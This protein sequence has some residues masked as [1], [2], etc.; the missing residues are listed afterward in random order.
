MGNIQIEFSAED[1]QEIKRSMDM[2]L[3]FKLGLG[4]GNV[5]AT[6]G[7][8][9]G[10][11]GAIAASFVGQDGAHY[12]PSE[13]GTLWQDTAGTVPATA[14]GDPI[15]RVD[16]I[17]GNNNH[18]LQSSASLRPT[19]R[20]SGDEKW[21][22]FGGTQWLICPAGA[23]GGNVVS[24]TM[25]GALSGTQIGQFPRPIAFGSTD[26]GTAAGSARETFGFAQD[27][28]LRFDGAFAAGATLPTTRHVRRGRRDGTRVYQSVN[29]VQT[30]NSTTAGADDAIDEFV[31]GGG[32]A[33]TLFIGNIHEAI[34]L[35]T[36]IDDTAAAAWDAQLAARHG[37]TL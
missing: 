13:E 36:Y 15:A 14:D 18:A 37:V 6:V 26:Q 11:N 4:V 1:V 17:S 29:G 28:S 24:L 32:T 5:K 23:L 16:D 19:L 9:T 20:V 30:T 34:F 27:G 8:L 7:P 35:N 21:I 22:E 2:G 25:A 31:L 10:H 33:G 3:G 12:L